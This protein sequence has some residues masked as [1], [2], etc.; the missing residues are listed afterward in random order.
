MPFKLIKESVFPKSRRESLSLSLRLP[1]QVRKFHRVV[2]E[3]PVVGPSAP[4]LSFLALG[5]QLLTHKISLLTALLCAFPSLSG[6]CLLSNMQGMFSLASF[7]SPS[8]ALYLSSPCLFPLSPFLS[9]SL[10]AL[11]LSPAAQL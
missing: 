1:K 8:L 3:E 11:F 4:F 2:Q 5:K 7:V 9:S 6:D 10:F